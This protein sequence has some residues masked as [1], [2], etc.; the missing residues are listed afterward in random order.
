[1]LRVDVPQFP[2]CR[3]LPFD[4]IRGHLSSVSSSIHQKCWLVH[5][6]VRR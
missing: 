3:S 5:P 4:F 2:S 1:V 6:C